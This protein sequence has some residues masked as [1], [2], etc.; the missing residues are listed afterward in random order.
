MA[1]ADI[2]HGLPAF[3]GVAP[4]DLQQFASEARTLH[5]RDGDVIVRQHAV[6][7]HLYVVMAGTL[8]VGFVDR[9]G[10]ERE[11]PPIA[12]GHAAGELQAGFRWTAPA[13]LR[14]R[15]DAVVAA[16]STEALDRLALANPVAALHVDA[17]LRPTLQRDRL[18][19]AV[20]ENKAFAQLDPAARSALAEEMEPHSLYGGEVLFR[21]G[22]IGDSVYVVVSG[23]VSVLLTDADGSVRVLAELGAGEVVGEMA[24]IGGEPRSATVVAARD[25]QLA[26]LGLAGLDRLVERYPGPMLRLL[27]GRLASRLRDMS[28]A[29]RHEAPVVTVAV[30]PASPEVPL[31]AVTARIAA[32]LA[33]LGPTRHLTSGIVD[34]PSAAPARRRCTIVMAAA[35]GFSNGSPP[36]KKSGGTCSTKRIPRSRRGPSDVCARPTGSCCWPTPRPMRRQAKSNDSCSSATVRPVRVTRWCCCTASRYRTRPGP[37]DGWPDG[38]STVTCTPG[39]IA[40][41][42]SRSRTV[43]H[44]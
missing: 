18:R 22:E 23:R 26:R 4:E 42:T 20:H 33:A 9:L 27:A 16:I 14:A 30:V 39:S 40:L 44:R 34:E 25:T 11:L 28:R 36:R 2:L 3:A 13:T 35:A 15:G 37:R 43:R 24:Y 12:A 19:A 38:H 8:A 21:Q 1:L 41:R 6:M 17:T 31:A 10:V 7:D 29:R 5:L 32:A